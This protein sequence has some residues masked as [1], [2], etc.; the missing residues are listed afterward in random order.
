MRTQVLAIP[1]F[2]GLTVFAIMVSPC[3]PLWNEEYCRPFHH[4]RRCCQDVEAP[5]FCEGPRI[6][7]DMSRYVVDAEEQRSLSIGAIHWRVASTEREE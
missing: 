3:N 7:H 6:E 1:G 2:M 5:F 4:L